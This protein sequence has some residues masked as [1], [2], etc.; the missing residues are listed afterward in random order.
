[1]NWF[2]ER[3]VELPMVGINLY[4]MFSMKVLTRAGGRLRIR[5]PY[6]NAEI[7][8]RLGDLYWD[9]YQTSIFISETASVGPVRRRRQWLE[10]SVA[11]VR[12]LRER[13][14]P[15]VGYTWWP[16]FALVTW[17][18]RQG[19]HAP[20]FYLKQMGLWDLD[21]KLN[22]IETELVPA[23]RKL[24]VNGSGSVGRLAA[25]SDYAYAL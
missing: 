7:I 5:M 22:R 4:P 9:R 11:A 3:K 6:A 12:R 2:L 13:A 24:A 16:L 19:A 1:L 20:E 25:K 18:Y 23:Y 10:D 15:I 21:A 8:E 17:A 14:I